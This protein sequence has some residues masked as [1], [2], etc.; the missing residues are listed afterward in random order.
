MAINYSGLPEHIRRGFREYIEHHRLPG[1]FIKACLENNLSEAMGRADGVNRQKLF[2]IVAFLYNEAP[3]E[4]WGSIA[5]VDAWVKVGMS[6]LETIDLQHDLGTRDLTD[7][8]T[9]RPI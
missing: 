5:K 3:F 9:K 4:C 6:D 2:D 7:P 1:G 8:F